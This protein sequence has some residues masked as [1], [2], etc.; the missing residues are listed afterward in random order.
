M[1]TSLKS[2]VA[3][4]QTHFDFYRKGNLWY[5]TD[6]GYTYPVPIEDIG[7]ASFL[8]TDKA[9]IHMRYIRKQMEAIEAG[10]DVE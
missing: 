9:L 7:D 8:A 2:L 5:K 3:G 10:N 6:D 1:S 4:K